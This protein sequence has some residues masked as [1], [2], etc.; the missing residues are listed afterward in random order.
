MQRSSF[1][2]QFLY[3]NLTVSRHYHFS[4]NDVIKSIENVIRDQLSIS[5]LSARVLMQH[6]VDVKM[7]TLIN[8]SNV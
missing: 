3:P 1:L 6:L 2:H 7:F 4:G 8:K 5:S